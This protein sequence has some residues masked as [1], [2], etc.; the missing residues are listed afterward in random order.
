MRRQRYILLVVRI[1]QEAHQ[2]YGRR[3]AFNIEVVTPNTPPPH[4]HKP[5]QTLSNQTILITLP[6]IGSSWRGQQVR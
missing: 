4:P 2:D 1:H 3:P 5:F 6:P